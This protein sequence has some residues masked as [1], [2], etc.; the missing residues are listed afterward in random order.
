MPPFLPISAPELIF[1]GDTHF[2]SRAQPGEAV[3]RD[4]FLRFLA[5]VRAGTALF[6]MGDIFDFFF[7]YRSVVHRR[8]L[9]L[10][11]ALAACRERG[12]EAHFIGGNHDY[13]VGSFLADE[14]GV[15]THRDEILLDAQGRRLVCAHGDL[16]IPRDWGYKALKTIIRNPAVV[17]ASRWIHPDLLDAV[18]AGVSAGSRKL[19]EPVHEARARALAEH[20]HRRFFARGN[21][22]FVMGHIHFPLIDSRD[23]HDFVVIG[24]WIE[25]T[26]FVRLS[27]GALTLETFTG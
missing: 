24:D 17:A 11:C 2:R 15:R 25:H 10:F 22:A 9:D 16:V 26:T 21:D 5:S 7:A 20:A 23:G 18:A 12:V 4:R 19:K 8:Y 3:R 6:L 13:W 1:V 27:G 14:L